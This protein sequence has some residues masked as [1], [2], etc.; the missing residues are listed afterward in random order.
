MSTVLLQIIMYNVFA[1]INMLYALLY[2]NT[3]Q[4]SVQILIYYSCQDSTSFVDAE[5]QNSKTLRLQILRGLA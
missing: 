4:V 3:I 1:I 5:Y 2:L